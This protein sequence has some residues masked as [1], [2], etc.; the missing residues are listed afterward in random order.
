MSIN[1]IT[2]FPNLKG[3]EVAFVVVDLF[4]KYSHFIPQNHMYTARGVAEVFAKETICFHRLPAWRE[5]F[6]L[7]E[8]HLKLSSSYHPESN[9]QTEYVNLCVEIYLR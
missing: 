5:M 4:S 9:G 3:Y 6:R 1:F 7:Q 8:T 2:G